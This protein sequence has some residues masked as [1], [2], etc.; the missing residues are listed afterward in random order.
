MLLSLSSVEFD[1][2]KLY[3]LHLYR[4]YIVF[5]NVIIVKRQN[6]HLM[7]SLTERSGLILKREL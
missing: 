6:S 3:N 4:L 2:H 7:G 1:T 5:H